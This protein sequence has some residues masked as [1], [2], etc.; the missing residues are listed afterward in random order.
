MLVG[1]GTNRGS[2]NGG[3]S[4]GEGLIADDSESSS[5]CGKGDGF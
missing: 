1:V 3:D 5:G 2:S 4:D